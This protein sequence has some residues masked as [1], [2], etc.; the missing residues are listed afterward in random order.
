MRAGILAVPVFMQ[1]DSRLVGFANPWVRMPVAVYSQ[2]PFTNFYGADLVYRHSF[3]D[4]AM[5]VQP[6]VGKAKVHI[7]ETGGHGTADLDDLVG[8]NL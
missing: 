6:Y 1:S 5:T 4:V 7:P 3:N 8:L 2:A